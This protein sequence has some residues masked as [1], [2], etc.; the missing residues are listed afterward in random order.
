[1]IKTDIKK[2]IEFKSYYETHGCEFVELMTGTKLTLY[3]KA[4][5]KLKQTNNHIMFGRHNGRDFYRKIQS[6]CWLSNLDANE[7]IN[8]HS[9]DGSIKQTSRDEVIESIYAQ[10]YK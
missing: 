7:T 3:Q 1:M 8:V 6:L 10:L 2:F 9:K 5:F 4:L